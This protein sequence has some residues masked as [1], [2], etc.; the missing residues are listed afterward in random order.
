MSAPDDVW[1]HARGL[2]SAHVVIRAQGR[3]VSRDVLAF[4]AGVCA[5]FSEAGGGKIP[6][7]CCPVKNVRKPK[8]S[9]AGFVTYT[10][11]ETVLGDPALAESA[12]PVSE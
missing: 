9:K 2:H 6:V 4:A 3:K 5:K 7:D 10:G 1:L 8:G 12:A 11:F